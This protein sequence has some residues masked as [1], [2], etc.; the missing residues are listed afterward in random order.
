[1]RS[2][3]VL[4]ALLFFSGGACRPGFDDA[5]P[6]NP[7]PPCA[8]GEL[9]RLRR[10]GCYGACP[11][12]SVSVCRDATVVYDGIVFVKTKG[13]H[14]RRLAPTTFTRLARLVEEAPDGP[15]PIEEPVNPDGEKLRIVHTREDG[16]Q[17]W[18]APSVPDGRRLVLAIEDAADVV[19]WVGTDAERDSL[20]KA[21]R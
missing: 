10:D 17:R 21:A 9:V 8:G 2:V 6:R 1:M 3:P 19:E 20:E 12:Y 13:R 5:A 15:S 18:L 11:V 4:A 16:R 14:S 7:A